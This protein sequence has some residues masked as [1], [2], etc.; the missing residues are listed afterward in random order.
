MVHRNSIAVVGL[1]FIVLMM[2]GFVVGRVPHASALGIVTPFILPAILTFTFL[3]VLAYGRAIIEM[4]TAFLL[5]RPKQ[6]GRKISPLASLLGYI[7]VIITL[8]LLVRTG[9]IQKFFNILQQTASL[10][11]SSG[12]QILR[13]NQGIKSAPSAITMALSYYTVLIFAGLIFLSVVLFFAAIRLAYREAHETFSGEQIKLEA[14]QVVQQAANSLRNNTEYEETILKC[15]RQMC[16]VLSGR[17]FIIASEQTAREFAS[18]VSQKLNLGSDAVKGLTF[19]FEE[20][21]YS[22]HIIS[23][24]KRRMAVNELGSLENALSKGAG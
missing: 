17:G 10:I 24:D 5:N 1:L 3:V 12:A 15:Y 2:T 23:D 20:A 19:L 11:A 8:I 14:L 9:V 4:L 22:A 13:T 7:V 16:N 21:R 18:T 6:E